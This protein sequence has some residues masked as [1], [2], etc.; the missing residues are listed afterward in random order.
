MGKQA[1][2]KARVSPDVRSLLK[3][4]AEI[5]GRSLSDFVITA[6][7]KAAEKTVVQADIIMSYDDQLRFELALI[8]PPP[9]APA[10]ERSIDCYKCV[11]R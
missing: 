5:E 8:D 7:R 1:R 10:M 11:A 3:R 2:L 4:A 6:A 9:L